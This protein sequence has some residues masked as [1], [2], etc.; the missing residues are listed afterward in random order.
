VYRRPGHNLCEP[1]DLQAV[2]DWREANDS[3]LFPNPRDAHDLQAV[4]DW[5][6]SNDSQLFPNPRDPHSPASAIGG[7]TG[8]DEDFL[9]GR[10]Q[11]LPPHRTIQND[12]SSC[13]FPWNG[14]LCARGL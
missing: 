2:Q 7:F 3:Q 11:V 12:M 13:A 4:Q 1:R 10:V 6:E 5:R 8:E 9:T 14:A